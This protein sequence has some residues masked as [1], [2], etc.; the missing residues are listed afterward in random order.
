MNAITGIII[1]LVMAWLFFGGMLQR[2][3]YR[4]SGIFHL[5]F[6]L[7]FPVIVTLLHKLWPTV[8]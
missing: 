1:Y 2:P 5:C 4:A 7:G 8:F 3:E 6:W